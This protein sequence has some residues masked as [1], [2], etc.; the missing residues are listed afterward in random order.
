MPLFEPKDFGKL[1]QHKVEGFDQPIPAICYR[2]VDL[3]SPYPIGAIATGYFELRGNGTLGLSS[4]Y[5]SYVPMMSDELSG[6]LLTLIDRPA[7][8]PIP[9]DAGH[10]DISVLAHFPVCNM[11]FA[12]KNGPVIWLRA[13]TT[14]LPGDAEISNTPGV[15]FQVS[16]D[17]SEV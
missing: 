6:T 10:C 7:A 15:V 11:R 1:S 13:F 5:N 17:G 16:C 12:V 8:R 9:L 2:G 3:K 4:L 14:M